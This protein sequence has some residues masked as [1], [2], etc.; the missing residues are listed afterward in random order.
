MLAECRVNFEISTFHSQRNDMGMPLVA[1]TT[2]Q[3]CLEIIIKNN[4][5]QISKFVWL[6]SMSCILLTTLDWNCTAKKKQYGK[7]L[8]Q[9][10]L[11]CWQSNFNQLAYY[12]SNNGIYLYYLSIIFYSYTQY[13]VCFVFVLVII[14]KSTFTHLVY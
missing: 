1:T 14:T 9:P 10:T 8:Q 5:Q 7:S 4:C 6:C 12:K 3:N 13:I 2:W 11:F